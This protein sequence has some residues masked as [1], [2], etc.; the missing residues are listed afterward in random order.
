MSLFSRRVPPGV[1]AFCIVLA[2]PH[3]DFTTGGVCTHHKNAAR[4][5]ITT[6]ES[7]RMEYGLGGAAVWTAAHTDG[8]WGE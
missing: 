7:A 6:G 4:E 8:L 1:G 2:P 3:A 5:N